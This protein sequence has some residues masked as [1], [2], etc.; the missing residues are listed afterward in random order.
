[1]EE[2]DPG[3]T[4]RSPVEADD[5]D[6]PTAEVPVEEI[7]EVPA[8]VVKTD[9]AVASWM[10]P[11]TDDLAGGSSVLDD[12]T[13]EDYL[14]AT[15]TEY[16]GLAESVR[17]AATE[18][19][20][21]QAVALVLVHVPAQIEHQSAAALVLVHQQGRRAGLADH[22]AA[23]DQ[24]E[25]EVAQ[26]RHAKFH[27]EAIRQ[28]SR[29]VLLLG[30]RNLDRMAHLGGIDDVGRRRALGQLG[31]ERLVLP[32]GIVRQPPRHSADRQAGEAGGQRTPRR[33]SPRRGLPP[34]RRAGEQL[35]Q[36]LDILQRFGQQ[37]RSI[38]I[39]AVLLSQKLRERS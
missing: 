19:H 35:W 28:P 3:T 38:P 27:V 24:I 32:D 25:A 33:R 30:R 16:Q 6:Q 10:A 21:L 2:N 5:D 23:A 15:T 7:S 31:V 8:P 37:C 20:E 29:Q 4:A 1:M 18:T 13:D 34:C 11:E 26:A 39:K 9:D 36:R 17:K 12:F 14:A 22:Q